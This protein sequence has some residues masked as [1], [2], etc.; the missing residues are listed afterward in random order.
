[1][2]IAMLLAATV[3]IAWGRDGGRVKFPGGKCYMFRV[4]LT[5][6]QGSPYTLDAPEQYLS[7]RAIDRRKRQHLDIDSTDLPISP[8]Y[9]QEVVS[10]GVEVVCQS[11]WNN[12]LL[13][14]GKR[15]DVLRNLSKLPFVRDAQRVWTSPDSLERRH[16]REH[17]STA[18]KDWESNMDQHEYGV[19][20]P[21]LEMLGG[22][23]LHK[24]GYR[25]RG[26]VIAVLDGGFMN[27][28]AI[29]SLQKVRVAGSA[30]FVF[31]RAE[32]IFKE[33]DHG[34][35]VLS[36]MAAD[37]RNVFLGS[38]PEA[39][40]WLLRC[41]DTQTET[42]AEEDYWASAVEFADS[43][44]VD[45]INS[46]LGYHDFDDRVH[47][48]Y[49]QLDGT[50]TMISR[51]ASMLAKKG[52]V[53]VCSAGNDGMGT[54]KKISFPAD[55]I[56]ILTV[57]AVSADRQNAAFSAVGPTADGRV[58][59]DVMAMGSPAT[60]ITGR[61]SISKDIG[62][63]FSAPLVAGLVACLWQALP[64]KSALEIIELVRQSGDNVACPDNI[65]GYGIPDFWKAFK[66]IR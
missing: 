57:G 48:K 9:I 23:M 52:M 51:T 46:S 5:D 20:Q 34:T 18:F 12:S 28:D 7:Q 41:E 45:V 58:K 22:L 36:M 35:K 3:V 1:M 60:V 11:K 16:V 65:Y 10:A 37:E 27:A 19:T 55:A 33:I 62:T 24:H 39:S 63:S 32:S 50:A 47:F 44:G 42:M 25:G 56:D 2:A 29:P 26:M 14:K 6:K 13:V 53:L 49:S 8:R 4:M 40:Y 64:G 17:Y 38:A 21:Q 61:G 54:W 59:P 15:L 43:A 30:D 31:P 66:S